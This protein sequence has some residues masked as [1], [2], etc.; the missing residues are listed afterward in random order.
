MNRPSG[1]DQR[2][3]PVRDLVLIGCGIGLASAVFF[4][5][6]AWSRS[7]DYALSSEEAPTEA[8]S[9]EE[10]TTTGAVRLSSDVIA[11]AGIEIAPVRATPLLDR[12][13]VTGT[14][15]ANQESLQEITPLVSGR[16][17]SVNVAL[18]DRVETGMPLF[19]LMSPE[20]AGLRGDL[21]AAEAELAE[22]DAVLS[23]T[24]QLVELGAGAGKDLVA[25]EAAYRRAE[26]QVTELRERLVVLG[27]SPSE[28]P[29]QNPA[30][31]TIVIDAPMSGTVI[32][33]AVN[34]G[35][36]VESGQRLLAL[37]DLDTVWVIVNVPEA[38]LASVRMRAPVQIR[39]PAID[40]TLA[41]R[42]SYVDPQLDPETRTARIRVEIPNAQGT[43]KLGMFVTV[44]IEGLRRPGSTDL[45]VPDTAIQ[46]IGERTV[47]FVVMPGVG[48]FEVRDVSVGGETG[49]R[50]IV[51]EGLSAGEAVV[52]AGGFTIKS[53]LLK[54]QFG[55]DEELE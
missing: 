42:I 4:A 31:S 34:R 47:V 16:V 35:M 50:R 54:G 39:A 52:T 46:Q 27:A 17:E 3:Q 7:D 10:A 24:R 48:R 53:Q 8:V 37:A 25:A 20:I 30:T 51:L 18:G 26:A 49:G 9:A 28:D 32:E 36:W 14:I 43:L 29:G 1:K 38:R 19:R 55:E 11:Q 6:T 41:G 23:R 44:M 13:N 2:A 33:R 15:Q 22:A 45:T 40:G 5:W 12:L 21:R